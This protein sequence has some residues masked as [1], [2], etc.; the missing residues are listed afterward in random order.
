MLS[1]G[2]ALAGWGD[3][4]PGITA[5]VAL[6][7]AFALLAA[8]RS[9]RMRIVWLSVAAAVALGW[10]YAPSLLLYLPPAA[11]NVAFG[12]FFATTLA[13][14]RE[15]RIA[16]FARLERGVD[17]PLDLARYARRLTWLWT[18]FFFVSAAVGLLLAAFAPLKLWS[19]F[20]NV[21]SY[22]AVAGLFAG[23]YLYR[24]LRFPHHTHAPFTAMIRM[25]MQARRSH[26]FGRTRP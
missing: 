5:I 3:W 15:P 16:W 1:H 13:P 20:V 10:R 11:L 6:T 19:A 24:R 18:V 25:V 22:L 8:S 12:L 17:L 4:M 7:I 2:A 9:A 26:G 21:A 14:G 23:E